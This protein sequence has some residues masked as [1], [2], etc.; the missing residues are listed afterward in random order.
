MRWVRRDDVLHTRIGEDLLVRCGIDRLTGVLV[1]LGLHVK[2][3]DMADPA[4]KEDPNDIL[5]LRHMMLLAIGLLRLGHVNDDIWHLGLRTR[6]KHWINTVIHIIISDGNSKVQLP[7][8][9]CLAPPVP[10]N[11]HHLLHAVGVQASR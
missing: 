2:A 10:W 3:L 4:A 8:R 6:K 7:S 11:P 1:Q 9:R 5:R